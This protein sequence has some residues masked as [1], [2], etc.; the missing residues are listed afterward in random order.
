MAQVKETYLIKE[1]S[2]DVNG[3]TLSRGDI[4]K[5]QGEYGSKFKFDSFV[6]NSISGAQWIDCFQLVMGRSSVFRSFSLDRVKR[7]PVK[8]KKVA[9]VNRGTASTTS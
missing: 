9:R 4:I 8:R 7:I 1:S 2:V 3:F 6:T 5:I